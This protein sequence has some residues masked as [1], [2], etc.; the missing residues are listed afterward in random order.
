MGGGNRLGTHKDARAH[1]HTE[2]TSPQSSCT[3]SAAV[4]LPSVRAGP[5]G[6]EP[7]ERV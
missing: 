5:D 4:F 6:T 2:N 3:R 7:S 1:A